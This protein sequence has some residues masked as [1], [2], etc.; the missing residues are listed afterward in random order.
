MPYRICLVLLLALGLWA[1]QPAPAP[2]PEQAAQRQDILNINE[3]PEG[4]SPYSV[5]WGSL[6]I[7]LVKYAN[8]EVYSGSL[9][10]E[11]SAFRDMVGQE[12]RLLKYE[13]EQEVE[14]VSIHREP[15]S[16]FSSFWFS[17]PEFRRR[18][19]EPS[20]ASTL[21]QGIR[22]GDVLSVRLFS[23]TDSTI[24]QSVMIKVADPFEE[25]VPAVEVPRPHY[26]GDV[27]GFQLVQKSGRRPLLRIDTTSEATRHIYELYR[28]NRLY[29]VVHVPGF[30]TRRRLLTDRDQLFQTLEIHHAELLGAGHDW[31]SLPEFTAFEGADVNLR[32][33]DM[34]ASP[35]SENYHQRDFRTHITRGL[36]L[37][38]GKE[39]LPICG[40]HLF[41]DAR[42]ERPE[43]YVADSLESPALLK[44]L[45]RVQPAST[46]YFDKL[47]V[48]N[49]S[50]QLMLFSVAFAFNIGFERPYDLTVEPLSSISGPSDYQV[51]GQKGATLIRM[52]N[53]ALSEA[54]PLLLGLDSTQLRRRDWQQD[55]RLDILFTSAYYSVEDGKT[56]ILRALQDKFGL[57]LE[58]ANLQESYQ[59]AVKDSAVLDEFR[60][61]SDKD[62]IQYKDAHNKTALLVHITPADLARFLTQE[63]DVSVVNRT[64]L[65]ADTKMKIEM[66]FASLASARES[67]SRHGM[68]LERVKEGATVTA[69]LR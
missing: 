26:D 61:V 16:R 8:P 63:L 15:Y 10:V 4:A 57:E 9:E 43:L 44:A 38:V 13:R 35:S 49:K 48:K 58:W 28:H 65:P 22:Q 20:V 55:P 69:H 41:I 50:G 1:C 14:V 3:R 60:V 21:R 45:L 19:L 52:H 66:D 54:L 23:K 31:L 47:I 17:Y 46:I 29:K 34:V 24:V 51:D 37:Q 56:L 5:E 27:F 40:F 33:G 59:L 53:Y 36:H 30:Q 62:F 67:L 25:Y 68:A 6:H 11:I 64:G 39:E 18:R 12:L 7:P 32:W 2:A 42:D